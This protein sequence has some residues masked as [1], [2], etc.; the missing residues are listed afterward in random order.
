M[1]VKG[2]LHM[3]VSEKMPGDSRAAR[4]LVRRQ[5][6]AEAVMAEGVVR[7]EDLT[8][9]FGI[10]LMTAHRDL[11]ELIA[12]GLLRKTRGVVG[13]PRPVSLRAAM[14]TAPAASLPKSVRLQRPQCN[15]SN[16]GKRF[17]LTIQPLCFR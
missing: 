1:T 12:R 7:I 6:I 13:H 15:L 4:Q 14:F 2:S 11:D 16:P 9:R 5:L 3:L 17:S 10:S 8:D